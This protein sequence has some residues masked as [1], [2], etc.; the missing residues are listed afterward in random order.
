M[1]RVLSDP[2]TLSDTDSENS[3]TDGLWSDTND[4]G[5]TI[6]GGKNSKS[7]RR[8][9]SSGGPSD[10][11]HVN[12]PVQGH[13][14][15]LASTRDTDTD[16]DTL[17]SDAKLSMILAKVSLNE[18]KVERIEHMLSS[19]VR[20]QKRI[21]EIETVIRSHD[22]R[23]RMLEYKSL[24]VEACSRR[25]NLLIYGI[26]ERRRENCVDRI[27]E[28]LEDD[29]GLETMDS[30]WIERAHPLGRYDKTKAS[31]NSGIL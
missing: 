29:L 14:H 24:D 31:R 3:D 18:D 4:G 10:D 23:L 28:F 21:S 5:F 20:K 9:V 11:R 15:D 1:F 27:L 30:T 8:R 17:S 22:D 6:V 12:D 2:I 16:F 13:V 26:A 25:N 19:V 7:K